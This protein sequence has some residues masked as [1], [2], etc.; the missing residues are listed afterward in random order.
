MVYCRVCRVCKVVVES[1]KKVRKLFPYFSYLN[2]DR[3]VAAC[4]T[5]PTWIRRLL[6][7]ES[8]HLRQPGTTHALVPGINGLRLMI[9]KQFSQDCWPPQCC[10]KLYS[11][12]K[13]LL[14]LAILGPA[15]QGV[16]LTCCKFEIVWATRGRIAC[17]KTI[18]VRSPD[19]AG[20]RMCNFYTAQYAQYQISETLDTLRYWTMVPLR[21]TRGTIGCF[22]RWVPRAASALPPWPRAARWNSTDGDDEADDTRIG[23]SVGFRMVSCLM[24]FME[25][26]TLRW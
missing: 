8:L 18:S 23:F 3:A 26:A 4:G 5:Q 15:E 16:A 2:S 11:E 17:S 24:H 10:L 20:Q 9:I 21:A 7:Q 13:I 6:I 14:Q 22:Q 1:S 12:S 25:K 19:N